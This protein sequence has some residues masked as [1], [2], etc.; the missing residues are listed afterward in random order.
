MDSSNEKTTEFYSKKLRL[1][2]LTLYKRCQ[3]QTEDEE[4]PGERRHISGFTDTHYN[5][6]RVNY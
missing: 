5:V 3:V 1:E 6:H 4:P 2:K